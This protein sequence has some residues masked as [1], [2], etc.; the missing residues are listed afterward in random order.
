M[1][2]LS[3]I[4]RAHLAQLG[5]PDAISRHVKLV[6]AP[7]ERAVIAIGYQS[8]TRFIETAIA[9][10]PSLEDA[11]EMLSS[12]DGIAPLLGA[13]IQ[14][15]PE[16]VRPDAPDWVVEGGKRLKMDLR[17]AR[18]LANKAVVTQ[19]YEEK[20]IGTSAPTDPF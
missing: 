2:D 19:H 6:R 12:R 11:L 4:A 3:Q 17:R 7:Q 14:G 13:G 5:V 9:N 16:A 8:A 15:L 20:V 18:D 10:T 1:D